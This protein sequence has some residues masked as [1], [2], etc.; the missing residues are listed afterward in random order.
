[1]SELETGEKIP[2]GVQAYFQQRLRN[3]LYDFVVA[4]FLEQEEAGSL[5]RADLARRI[6]KSPA[7]ITRWLSSPRN[8]RL[9]T[10]SDLLLGI[11]AEELVPQSQSILGRTSNRNIIDF[12][13]NDDP[14]IP[15]RNNSDTREP[16][17]FREAA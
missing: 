1:M 4:K 15:S 10:L 14:P 2:V 16:A 3:N 9:S 8:W 17:E 13:K 12:F 5:S 6:G 7:V 11:S